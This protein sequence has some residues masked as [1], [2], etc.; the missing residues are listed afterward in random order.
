[1]ETSKVKNIIFCQNDTCR[2]YDQ[3]LIIEE[4]LAIRVE[5]EP[6]SVVM[7]TPGEEISHAAGFCL[8]EGLIDHP[9]D[10]NTIGLCDDGDA[11]VVTVTLTPERK[12]KVKDLLDRRGFVSQTSCGICGKEL[13][14]DMQQILTSVK[15]ETTITVKQAM[16][17]VDKLTG[18]Q[19]LYKAT[20]GAHSAMVFDYDL[21]PLSQAEDVGRH[22]AL[23]KAIGKVFM[24][25][26]L[27]NACLAAL[28]SRIS[29]ELVQKAN[30]A[31]LVFVVGMSRPTS[32]AVE[33]GQA[34]GMTIA[35]LREGGVLVFCGKE[36]FSDL[37]K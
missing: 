30:R 36:R 2:S 3:D 37:H 4:P 21:N 11:N 29:Y 24:D 19:E 31:G 17:C 9:D 35:S 32:L 12:K 26:K 13:I 10:I 18:K 15:D 25:G 28:S 5:G 20:R 14:S 33:M 6:Y 1:M 22:N 27:E 16:E 8:A 34:M 7:R 23:D